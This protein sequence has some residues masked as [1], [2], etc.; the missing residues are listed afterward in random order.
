[1]EAGNDNRELLAGCTLGFNNF[2]GHMPAVNRPWI[3]A[4]AR[5]FLSWRPNTFLF[6]SLCGTWSGTRS[7]TESPYPSSPTILRG[8]FVKR[9]ICLYAQI[10]QDLRA[11]A[12]IA[13]VRRK[14]QRLIG[15]DSVHAGILK[16]VRLHLVKKPDTAAF[17][18]HIKKNAGTFLGNA[19]HGL[20]QLLVAIATQ[21]SKNISSD[22]LR[23]DTHHDRDCSIDLALD[24]GDMLK[25]ID[26]G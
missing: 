13:Q 8:L 1:M 20:L 7:T 12:V 15:L 9:R 10:D 24:Q 5:A 18:A 22:A 6:F 17:L 2:W 3:R 4:S 11:D 26:L 16:S 21:R 23:L 19:L 25:I 14:A